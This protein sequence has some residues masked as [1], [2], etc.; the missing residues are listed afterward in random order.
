MTF[1][2]SPYLLAP[3]TRDHQMLKSHHTLKPS[4]LMG[5]MCIAVRLMLALCRPHQSHMARSLTHV[6]LMPNT[7]ALPHLTFL[8]WLASLP[9]HGC[10]DILVILM[11]N[12][13]TSHIA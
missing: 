5:T 6:H 12:S 1:A 10:T 11:Y 7:C 13:W 8:S 4:H 3:I 9:H 2:F